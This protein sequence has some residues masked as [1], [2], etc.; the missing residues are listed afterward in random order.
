MSWGAKMAQ[1]ETGTVSWFGFK[2]DKAGVFGIF[3]TFNDEAGRDAHLKGEIA[4]AL[5]AKSDEYF[6]ETR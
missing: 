2:E 3:D 4:Q 5:M 6:A 1:T